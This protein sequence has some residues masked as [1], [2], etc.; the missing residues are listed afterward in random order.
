MNYTSK[1][2]FIYNVWYF[3]IGKTSIL[4]SVFKSL[5]PFGKYVDSIKRL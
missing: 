3:Q 2:L 5:P 1:L 4:V